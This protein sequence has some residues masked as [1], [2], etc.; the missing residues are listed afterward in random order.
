MLIDDSFIYDLPRDTLKVIANCK[1]TP[2]EVLRKLAKNGSAAVR[3]EVATN[4]NTPQLV[5]IGLAA[6]EYYTVRT[7]V[8]SNS[9]TPTDTLIQLSKDKCF[10][11]CMALVKNPNAPFEALENILNNSF[12]EYTF[13]SSEFD[14]KNLHI[15]AKNHPYYK[16]P[17]N[18]YLS[19][20][21]LEALKTLITASSDPHLKEL[22]NGIS[23]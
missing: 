16:P 11:V 21:Q 3:F 15:L 7:G 19:S 18:H 5:L 12:R 17:A 6:D 23:E 4:P 10:T 13:C 2:F 1:T 20:K 14:V 22:F 8:A 9:N